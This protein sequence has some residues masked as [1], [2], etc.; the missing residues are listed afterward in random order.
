MELEIYNAFVKAGVPE[1]EAKAAVESINKEIDKRY[2]LHAQQLATRG[3]IKQVRKDLS[4]A[5]FEI[6][7]WTIATMFAAV[8]MKIQSLKS[9]ITLMSSGR[10]SSASCQFDSGTRREISRSSHALSASASDLAASS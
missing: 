10:C 4:E 2:S 5:K 8:G 1:A 6:L 9:M 7:K 3:D